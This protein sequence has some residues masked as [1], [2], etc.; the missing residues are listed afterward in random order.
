M[1]NAISRA[2]IAASARQA[3][4]ESHQGNKVSNPYM[5][6]SQDAADWDIAFERYETEL[7]AEQ[8]QCEASA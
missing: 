1:A 4:I 8:H 7:L 5:E 2:R 3:V 6:G